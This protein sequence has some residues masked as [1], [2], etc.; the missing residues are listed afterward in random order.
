MKLEA[1]K[2]SK[3]IA[4]APASLML[5]GE[6]A[7][8]HN[9]LALV[10]AVNRRITVSLSER[11][12]DTIQIDSQL[13]HLTTSLK[14]IKIT[15]PFEFVTAAIL[16]IKTQLKTGFNLNIHADFSHQVGLGSSAAITVATVAVLDHWLSH[17]KNDLLSLFLKART[18]VKTVQGLGSGADVAASVWGGTLVYHMN[19]VLVKKLK[20]NP[21]ISVVYSGSKKPTKEVVQW[22]QQRYLENPET[23]D[24]I[25]KKINQNTERAE[26]LINEARWPELGILMNENQDHMQSLGLSNTMLDTLCHELCLKPEILGAKIS[27]SG[28]GDC[29]VAIGKLNSTLFPQ[30]AVQKSLGVYE[31]EVEISEEGLQYE[32]E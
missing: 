23:I 25:F 24:T 27:G 5:A 9:Y 13:G 14:E 6:H 17:K 32:Q 3:L 21:P 8:L 19:P 31:I 18:L 2:L 20:H 7:V 11:S 12:D 15:P 28:L 29:V 30:N 1:Y 26:N 22:L 4:S 16:A 10:C